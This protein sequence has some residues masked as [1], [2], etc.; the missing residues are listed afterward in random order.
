MFYINNFLVTFAVMAE[1]NAASSKPDSLHELQSA[2][3]NCGTVL[4]SLVLDTEPDSDSSSDQGHFDTDAN[5]A[6]SYY[7]CNCTEPAGCGN[8]KPAFATMIV[9]DIKPDSDAGSDSSSD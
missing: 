1:I 5:S 7:S 2:I 9:S 4:R 6:V 3:D 8:T